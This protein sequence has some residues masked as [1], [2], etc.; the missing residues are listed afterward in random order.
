M[1]IRNLFDAELVKSLQV[2][3]L[4]RLF[5]FGNSMR[6]VIYG[7]ELDQKFEVIDFLVSNF[8]GSLKVKDLIFFLSFRFE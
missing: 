5:E 4:L 2:D 8:C 3:S 7:Q 6:S 1:S